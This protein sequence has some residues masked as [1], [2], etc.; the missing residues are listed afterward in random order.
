[1]DLALKSICIT[2]Q[3]VIVTI[4]IIDLKEKAKFIH[5]WAIGEQSQ[6]IHELS[7]TNGATAVF[8]KET[9]ESLSKKRL[10]MYNN[11]ILAEINFT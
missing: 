8:V 7:Q 10:H 5:F 1:M 9:K 6:A 4:D 2:H 11:R 3:M